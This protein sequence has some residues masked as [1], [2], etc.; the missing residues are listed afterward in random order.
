VSLFQS[1]YIQISR[2]PKAPTLKELR[3]GRDKWT[4][5]DVPQGTAPKFKELM[6]P[7]VR[8]HMGQHDDPWGRFSDDE[9]QIH[10]DQ[11]FTQSVSVTYF[12]ANTYSTLESL[13][14]RYLL[15]VLKFYARYL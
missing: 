9:L 10:L 7:L 11:V 13:S 1:D 2:P 4:M 6:T 14:F 8:V 5:D 12:H 15:R 3:H